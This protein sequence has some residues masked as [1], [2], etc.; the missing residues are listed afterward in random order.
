M[1][2]AA[3]TMET[4]RSRRVLLGVTGSVAAVKWQE[5]AVA[6]TK[7]GAEV[8]IVCTDS[9][10]HF[11][12]IA[13]AYNSAAAAEFAQLNLATSVYS[14]EVEWRSYSSVHADPVL[15]IE[16]RKWADVLLI[17]PLSAN[18]LAKIASGLCDNLLTSI[19]RAWE[20]DGDGNPLKPIVI[21][22][23]MNTAMWN[24]PFTAKQLLVAESK[25]GAVTVMPI[26]KQLAC[27]DVGTGALARV[28]SIVE[29]VLQAAAAAGAG[30]LRR[31]SARARAQISSSRGETQRPDSFAW[32]FIK[33]VVPVY[34]ALLACMG[35]T[36]VLARAVAKRMD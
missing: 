1:L 4:P 23:A 34:G 17:A 7:A 30:Q 24:H 33:V 18:T 11:T 27:G 29:A 12:D 10:K 9:A 35:A 32:E 8:R 28:D 26:S 2:T 15:H 19:V 22:P 5:L 31:T 3:P 16:L 6:L 13:H 36:I 20:Y 25:L 21:A 14:D